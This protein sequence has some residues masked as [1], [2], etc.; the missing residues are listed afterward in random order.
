MSIE[1]A[2]QRMFNNPC[3]LKELDLTGSEI[4][5]MSALGYPVR[6][7]DSDGGDKYYIPAQDDS[8]SLVISEAEKGECILKWG[9]ASDLHCGSVFFDEAGL[10][11]FLRTAQDE[12]C[13]YVFISGDLIEGLY[14]GQESQ[15]RYLA[16]ID[17]A[18]RLCDVLSVYPLTYIGNK[19]NHTVAVE[20]A[21]LVNPLIMLEKWMH[22]FYYLNSLE[23]NVIIAGTAIIMVHLT[24][25][26]S[27]GDFLQS[28]VLKDGKKVSIDGRSWTVSVLVLQIG[29]RHGRG[30]FK[31]YGIQVVRPGTFK[32]GCDKNSITTGG[33]LVE[34]LISY[35]KPLKYHSEFISQRIK[36]KPKSKRH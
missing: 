4:L 21:G 31:K 32:N 28:E 25:G 8:A 29:H 7:Q 24:N 30:S 36:R 18:K 5:E 34:A 27:A 14:P 17:Q 20:K 16:P 1:S 12:G 3:S 22:N 9:A 13:K 26:K 23:C 2:A 35:G 33:Y 19:G 10:R 6:V 15:L 11:H